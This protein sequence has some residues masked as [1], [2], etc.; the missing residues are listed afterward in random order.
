MSHEFFHMNW[1][2]IIFNANYHEL[3]FIVIS[4]IF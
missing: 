4:L 3:C 2:R 1:T